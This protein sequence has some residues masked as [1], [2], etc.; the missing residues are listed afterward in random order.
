MRNSGLRSNFSKFIDT[1]ECQI[2]TFI[3]AGYYEMSSPHYCRH[4]PVQLLLVNPRKHV[5][6]CHQLIAIQSNM[7]KIHKQTGMKN[8]AGKIKAA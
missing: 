1:P 7:L 4:N 2:P 6:N 8:G 3:L 5:E